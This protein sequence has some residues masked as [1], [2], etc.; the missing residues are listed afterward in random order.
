MIKK[1]ATSPYPGIRPVTH[2]GQLKGRARTVASMVDYLE[3][4]YPRLIELH[5]PSGV[6][7][8]S[9]LRAG[10]VPRLE[11]QG[12]RVLLISD[13]DGILLD[14]ADAGDSYVA[15]VRRELERLSASLEAPAWLDAIG[16]GD[17][18][19]VMRQQRTVVIFDQFE[20]LLRVDPVLARSL[21]AR[22]CDL[23]SEVDGYWHIVAF[24]QEVR[25]EIADLVERRLTTSNWTAAG[26]EPVEDVEIERLVRDPLEV[27]GNLL[28]QASSDFV[29]AIASA[30]EALSTG[31]M[32][33][34]DAP[35]RY[36][37]PGL[38]HLQ[39]LLAVC[40]DQ[41]PRDA[42]DGLVQLDAGLLP[43]DLVDDPAALFDWGLGQY[44]QARIAEAA[45]TRSQ[46][47]RAQRAVSQT[48]ARIVPHLW[49]AGFKT[50]QQT[51][52]LALACLPRLHDLRLTTAQLD[53]VLAVAEQLS[54]PLSGPA[55]SAALPSSLRERGDPF[56]VAGVAAASGLLP[57]EVVCE[58]VATFEDA[59]EILKRE[60]IV[61]VTQGRDRRIVGL[62]H[63]ALGEQL[64]VW[65]DRVLDTPWVNIDSLV[66]VSGEQVL[67]DV[68]A[69]KYVDAEFEWRPDI[70]ASDYGVLDN[71]VWVGCQITA[72]FHNVIFTN[73]SFNG[74]VF[75]RC[76]FEDVRFE[77][78]VFWGAIFMD[79]EFAGAGNV[80]FDGGADLRTLTFLWRDDYEGPMLAFDPGGAL[81]LEGVHGRGLFVEGGGGGP[82]HIAGSTLH[83]VN[84]AGRGDKA[85]LDSVWVSDSKVSHL[86]I[87]VDVERP[88]RLT[89]ATAVS[90]ADVGDG[91]LDD[92]FQCDSQA[93]VSEGSAVSEG[94]A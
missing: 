51:R 13:W 2:R 68:L 12:W 76:R 19:E 55:I 81:R 15:I 83:H 50:Y 78:C 21:L 92:A 85:R 80:V 27:D 49:S 94:P 14:P 75:N 69:E 61:R 4:N 70:S 37:Q 71:L 82:I 20:E 42:S 16:T 9:L 64:A 23:V 46:D 5:G 74:S 53:E 87:G 25:H 79:C 30:W 47:R 77:N 62:S 36:I 38:L 89:G 39:A 48:A 88:V 60:A 18:W 40:W 57:F 31:Q 73:C 56:A 41:A 34:P 84:L 90:F 59:L 11:E 93:T 1:A 3:N 28:G 45:T 17:F 32:P 7:K 10:L 86:Q 26:V 33:S 91:R 29:S 66:V 35:A 44:L 22:V 65:K 6:G 8:S 72:S 58:L 24:R 43:A 54:R 67:G 52:D 63:D